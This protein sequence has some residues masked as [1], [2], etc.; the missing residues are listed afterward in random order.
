MEEAC[1]HAALREHGRKL[2]SCAP[3]SGATVVVSEHGCPCN[4]KSNPHGYGAYCKRWEIPTQRPW[5]YVDVSCPS[6]HPVGDYGRFDECHA[7]GAFS[8][9]PGAGRASVAMRPEEAAAEAREEEGSEEEEA[10]PEE[11]AEPDEPGPDE[12]FAMGPTAEDA[13]PPTNPAWRA[14]EH[15]CP[16]NGKSNPHGYG[17]YCKRWEIPT[18]RP[19]CYVDVSCPSPHPVGDYGRFDECRVDEGE[20]GGAMGGGGMG[21]GGMGPGGGMDPGGMGAGGGMATSESAPLVEAPLRWKA[22]SRGVLEA[23][24][25]LQ[26]APSYW[27]TRT[28]DGQRIAGAPIGVSRG[29]GPISGQAP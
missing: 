2:D 9:G 29:P 8:V 23:S 14:S 18:Q 11:A 7:G 5:C 15:G 17:A 25:L 13:A 10:E 3:A 16:C 20:G 26:R 28:L 27:T 4:G 21:P 22:R 1:P 19:W 24:H 12:Y 6:P